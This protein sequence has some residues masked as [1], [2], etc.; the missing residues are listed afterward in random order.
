AVP[1]ADVPW[2]REEDA[3]L[4][5]AV[6]RFPPVTGVAVRT[7]HLQEMPGVAVRTW[8]LLA[9]ILNASVS[10]RGRYRMGKHCMDYYIGRINP[11]VQG[12]NAAEAKPPAFPP[13]FQTRPPS[14]EENITTILK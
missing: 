3:V 7:W 8:H 5:E 10:A 9:S 1:A 6:E 12:P 11:S 13:R 14:R 2:T 4:R